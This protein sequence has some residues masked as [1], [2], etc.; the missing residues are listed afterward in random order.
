[1]LSCGRLAM[2]SQGGGCIQDTKVDASGECGKT[3]G[4][5]W[6]SVDYKI[7]CKKLPCVL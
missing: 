5:N 6:K 4:G 1:M 2:Q 3:C 7:C